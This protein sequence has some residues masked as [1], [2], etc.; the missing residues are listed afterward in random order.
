M[1]KI[2]LTVVVMAFISSL[3]A[4]GILDRVKQR[5][6][7][8]VNQKVDEKI[9]KAV[10]KPI[11]AADDAVSG[12]NKGKK[13]SGSNDANSGDGNMEG[14][15]KSSGSGSS[16]G[17]FKT[18]SKFDFVPGEKLVAAED[19]SQDNIGDFPA[20]WNTNGSGEI[21]TTNIAPGRYLETRKEVTMYPEWVKNLPENF[22]LEF[23]LLCND[24]FNF[25][26]SYFMVGFT[27]EKNI[28]KDWHAYGRFGNG[29]DKNDLVQIGFHP[30]SAGGGQGMTTFG[31]FKKAKQ[32]LRNEIEQSQFVTKTKKT[33]AHISIWRQGQRV[34]V[35][36]NEKKVW[37]I[38]RALDE[39]TKMNSLFFRNDGASN[40]SDAFYFG[41]V[42]VAVGAA[43]TRN[44]LITEGKFVTH[45]ILFDVNS[46]K[47][48]PESYGALKDIAN[49]LGENA[50]VKVKIVGHTDADGDDKSNLDLSKRR[51]DAV[52]EMLSKEFSID[53][54]RMQTEGK[55]EN[56]PVDVNNTPA[57]K[58][59]NR[60]VEFIKM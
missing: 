4:Q 56:Q 7:N 29:G 40:E 32:E 36:I 60:R 52:K 24:N 9:D 14:G 1:K 54:S 12:K 34:R 55:G 57:G 51:A 45:G 48:K 6:K 44:K 27:T 22:T 33:K 23:D 26:S 58:A 20:K 8:K 25:Y 47:I 16:S 53:A 11:D 59:N 42:R 17:S 19:F 31:S 49:V 13:N 28:S 5:A 10:S 30:T 35:Y 41:N 43:D 3:Q 15:E 38:P 39:N 2:I 37:D 21:V 46:D 18:F 50:E